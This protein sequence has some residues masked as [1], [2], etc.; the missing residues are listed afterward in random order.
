MGDVLGIIPTIYPQVKIVLIFLDF[1][2]YL[3]FGEIS[4]FKRTLKSFPCM[5]SSS[6]IPETYAFETL[7][8]SKSEV[9]DEHPV[10]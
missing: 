5:L 7:D 6:L 2:K 4:N 10:G 1:D 3:V 8:L 9:F